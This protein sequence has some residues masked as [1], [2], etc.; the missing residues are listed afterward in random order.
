M[1]QVPAG[2]AP[3]LGIVGSGRVARHLTFYFTQLGLGVRTWSR[4]LDG[5]TP[6]ES[7][8]GC[9]AVLLLIP[10]RAVEPFVS[11]W[12]DLTRHRLVHC[13]G[14]LV[15][16]AA[17]AAHPLMTFGPTLYD[18]EV[19]RTIPFV[20]DDD[21]APLDALIPGLP[22]PWFTIPAG[23]RPYYHAVCVLAGNFS[24]LLWGKLFEELERLGLPASA[25]HPYL[26]RV[27]ANLLAHREAALTGP[28]TRGDAATIETNLR[29]LDG[30]AYRAVY[31][32]FVEAHR[33]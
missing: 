14:S 27:T 26:T 20:L 23:E 12:P 15:T 31:A 13:S 17:E 7:L 30:D 32:A 24:T 5:P 29:A 33:R 11:T 28:L 9:G 19:Y 16:Q 10:D 4:S 6:T 3:P 1:R 2:G 8:D 21:G 25:A 22:N 18:P